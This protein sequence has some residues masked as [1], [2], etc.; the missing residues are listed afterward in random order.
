[1]NQILLIPNLLTIARIIFII[2]SLYFL[3][4]PD[5]LLAIVFVSFVL[6]TDFLDGYLARKLNQTSSLGALLDPIA[7]KL[8]VVAFFLHL[9]L[10]NSVLEFYVYLV[11]TRDI[12][13]LSAI[14]ILKGWKKID[15][16]VKPKLVPKIGTAL[17]FILIGLY[18]LVYL[19]SKF[20]Q[21][22]GLYVDKVELMNYAILLLLLISIPIEIYIL[23]TFIPRFFQIYKGTHDTFE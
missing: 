6:I 14:P 9:L 12:L 20:P 13:Q 3:E 18:E 16:K 11:F 1:M 5:L 23:I 17:N 10:R 7:D 21:L 19:I 15:F 2:P 8:V 4:K 22:Y